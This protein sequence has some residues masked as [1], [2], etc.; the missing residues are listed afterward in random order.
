MSMWRDG[1]MPR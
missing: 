1:T